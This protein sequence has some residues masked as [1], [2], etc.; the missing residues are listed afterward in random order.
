VNYEQ[1]GALSI[2]T[3]VA[4]AAPIVPGIVIE[5]QLATL[6]S[7]TANA[8]TA[9]TVT[10]LVLVIVDAPFLAVGGCWLS[11]RR[12][13]D[14]AMHERNCIG[15]RLTFV[16]ALVLK[17]KSGAPDHLSKVAVLRDKEPHHSWRIRGRILPHFLRRPRR[18]ETE[19]KRV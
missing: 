16:A 11:C 15:G 7:L 18:C 4:H 3:A 5:A 2:V 10:V 12:R 19:Q 17:P 6:T 14:L 8:A 1:S 13:I 9:T